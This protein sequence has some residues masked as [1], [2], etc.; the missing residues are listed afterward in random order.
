M[1]HH[2]AQP[3]SRRA[4]A[5]LAL[6]LLA[7]GCAGARTKDEIVFP[8]P[9]DKGRIKWVRT[10]QTEDDLRQSVWRK[11]WKAIVPHD[12]TNALNAP[13]GLA[14][15]PD[16]GTLYVAVP[17]RSRI[18]AIDLKRGVFSAIGTGGRT[19]LGRPIGV[20]VDAEGLVYVSDKTASAIAVFSPGGELLRRF[21]REK[22]VEPTGIA[23]DRKAQIVYV[24]ND[25]S[26]QEGRHSVEAFSLAGKHLRTIGGGRSSE[27]GQ[28]NFPRSVTVSRTG[29][30]HVVD[31]LNFR[32]QVFDAQGRLMRFYGTIGS[33]AVG[34]F[35]KIHSVAF[36]TFENV[37]VADAVQGV[38][39]LNRDAQ[40]LMMFAAPVIRAPSAIAIDSKNTIYVADLLHAVHEFKL[41]DTTAADS[42]A[43]PAAP[44]SKPAAKPAPA[45][46]QPRN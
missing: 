8:P 42:F 36:D 1:P 39:V 2:A 16:D 41:V 13:T 29:E 5:A 10:M 18:V 28:F 25:A 22:L 7:S 43:K 14:V 9:P 21:G 27:P 46:S 3:S 44:A 6:V 23:I 12:S 32:I 26:R 35:D 38:H 31:M 17:H 34:Q 20:A 37:Y 4:A 11:I 19:P 15:S 40:P 33:G 24:V 45:P 30:L